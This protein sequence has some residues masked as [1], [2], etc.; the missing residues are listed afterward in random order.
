MFA[1]LLALVCTLYVSTSAGW[2]QLLGTGEVV[3]Y[4]KANNDSSTSAIGEM[5]AE[6]DELMRSVGVNLHWKD[7]KKTA[8]GTQRELVVLELRG[9]C[10]APHRAPAGPPLQTQASLASSAV[11]D[12]HILPFT[13]V[14]CGALTRFIGRSVADLPDPQRDFTYGRAMG[15]LAAHEFYHVLGQRNEHTQTGIAK[16]EFAE[17]DLLSDHLEF[18]TTV[19]AKNRR[20]KNVE[21]IAPGISIDMGN[22]K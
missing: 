18:E 10:A 13:W 2:A 5:K 7:A 15:R 22:E 21:V 12:G 3:V 19:V 6:M 11:S 17:S 4:L 9:I 20:S 8:G 1:R 16:A 14:D